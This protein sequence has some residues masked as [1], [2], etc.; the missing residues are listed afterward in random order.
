MASGANKNLPRRAVS[1]KVLRD[2]PFQI[3]CNLWYDVYQRGLASMVFKLLDKNS[4]N[5]Y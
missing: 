1:N 4:R 3:A 2:K 5:T